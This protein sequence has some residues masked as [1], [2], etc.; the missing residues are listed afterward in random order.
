[1]S[2][3]LFSAV[4]NY[5]GRQPDNQQGIKQYVTTIQNQAAWIYS[6]LSTGATIMRP[7]NQKINVV[8]DDNVQKLQS[9]LNDASR[10]STVVPDSAQSSI[11]SAGKVGW[12]FIGEEKGT[13]NCSKVGVNDK[14]MSGQ[15]F[16][17]SEQCIKK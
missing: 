9:A 1:M 5:S 17:T 4:N 3:N 16:D 10:S 14:C 6:K 2:S 11:Q 7:A 12:C 8:D 13:R 15:V